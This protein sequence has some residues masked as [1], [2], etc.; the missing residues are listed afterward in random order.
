VVFYL[1][2]VSIA[3]AE[4]FVKVLLAAVSS[5]IAKILLS[6]FGEEIKWVF[7]NSSYSGK[8]IG[9]IRWAKPA[10]YFLFTPVII[11]A[12]WE[13]ACEAVNRAAF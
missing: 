2:R 13:L 6:G 9:G 11:M 7:G 1:G 3:G 12:L 10:Q 4:G 8:D 5:A